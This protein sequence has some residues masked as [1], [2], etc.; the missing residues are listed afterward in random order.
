MALNCVRVS[1][2]GIV[3][4]ALLPLVLFGRAAAHDLEAAGDDTVQSPEVTKC[5]PTVEGNHKKLIMGPGVT[6]LHFNCGE[7]A[8]AALS[9]E[10]A[11][12]NHFYDTS[13]CAEPAKPLTEVA[14]KASLKAPDNSKEA[15]TL[16][17]PSEGRSA[18]TLF[19]KCSLT[20]DA[21]PDGSVLKSGNSL[22][23]K[24]QTCTLEIDVQDEQRPPA[25]NIQ[26]PRPEVPENEHVGEL[27]QVPEAEQ[28]EVC[29]PENAAE[30]AGLNL[31]VEPHNTTVTFSCGSKATAELLPKI[32]SHNVYTDEKCTEARPL[33]E[34]CKGATLQIRD[35][36]VTNT[37]SVAFASKPDK[38]QVL[39]YAC[40]ML[41]EQEVAD[42][43]FQQ[44]KRCVVKI[45]VKPA[46]S[47]PAPAPEAWPATSSTFFCGTLLCVLYTWVSAL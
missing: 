44:R 41:P 40:T 19:Y 13:N 17:I 46:E 5:D 43:G 26:N 45:T 37:Y 42:T 21:L 15:Y 12:K 38:E 23:G 32:W 31:T 27:G 24:V 22:Q 29:N 14:P 28:V 10:H 4:A 36:E 34:V 2:Y 33:S 25:G 9:P 47:L 11:K 1:A 7:D 3:L 18:K 8:R 35:G 20:Q 39:Y 6:T 30:N 16:S